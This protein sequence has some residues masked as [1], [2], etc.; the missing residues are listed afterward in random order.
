[1]SQRILKTLFPILLLMFLQSINAQIRHR[2]TEIQS[3]DN[4]EKIEFINMCSV[5]P[6]AI[7]TYVKGMITRENSDLTNSIEVK[8]EQFL[9]DI[10]ELD[11]FMVKIP[12]NDVRNPNNIENNIR[13]FDRYISKLKKT[14]EYFEWYMKGGQGRVDPST[15]F[16]NVLT[17][18]TYII[19]KGWMMFNSIKRTLSNRR[20]DN[21]IFKVAKDLLS[22]DMLEYLSTILLSIF[23]VLLEKSEKYSHPMVVV[24]EFLKL[25]FDRL[26]DISLGKEDYQRNYD[27]LKFVFVQI[28]PNIIQ[29]VWFRDRNT[30]CIKNKKEGKY[31]FSY[32]QKDGPNYGPKIA[33]GVS[34]TKQQQPFTVV[35]SEFF[36]YQIES[37]HYK[38]LREMN[39]TAPEC[40]LAQQFELRSWELK[41][42]TDDN[43][44]L[45]Y[46]DLNWYLFIKDG[47]INIEELDADQLK[48]Y[49][50]TEWLLETC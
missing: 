29:F 39:P 42:S 35:L 4:P 20:I 37:P 7:E 46:A 40:P 1:M 19:E 15:S 26:K 21:N 9:A 36:F 28:P 23:T 50:G 2:V 31:L 17:K 33:V 32:Y 44:F 27:K 13:K 45:I 34:E 22:R 41:P 3:K 24:G 47:K 48:Y 43:S 14:L 6:L 11:E 49:D 12:S 18:E 30:F 16:T 5:S 8:G 25:A 38:Q 10:R